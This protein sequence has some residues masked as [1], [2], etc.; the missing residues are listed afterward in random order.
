M[1]F[2]EAHSSTGIAKAAYLEFDVTWMAMDKVMLHTLLATLVNARKDID[3]TV[4]NTAIRAI[5]DRDT[6]QHRSCTGGTA[7]FT[8]V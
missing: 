3:N 6:T 4:S 5:R 8:P 2:E 1:P 7:L